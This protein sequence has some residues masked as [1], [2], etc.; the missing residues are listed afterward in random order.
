[1]MLQHSGSRHEAPH[2]LTASGTLSN[3][4]SIGNF[5][6]LL[7]FF[8]KNCKQISPFLPQTDISIHT[9]G[10][11][12][13]T[14][15][16][17]PQPTSCVPDSHQQLTK[18]ESFSQVPANTAAVGTCAWEIT[19]VGEVPRELPEPKSP[20]ARAARCALQNIAETRRRRLGAGWRVGS[21]EPALRPL[22]REQGLA[23]GTDSCCF[24]NTLQLNCI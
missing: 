3:A 23:L 9:G 15:S 20:T 17:C 16:P 7:G 1:M 12:H 14:Q 11:Y 2:A 21:G 13:Q 10:W 24:T 6:G 4:S 18:R 5:W 19:R 22:S 8:S